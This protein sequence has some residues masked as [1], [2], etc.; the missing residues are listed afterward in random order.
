MIVIILVNWNGH[1]DTVECLEALMRLETPASA[2]RIIISD[3]LSKSG[4][5]EHII[6]WCRG[7]VAAECSS[8]AWKSL[9]QIRRYQPDFQ[10]L[11]LS[12]AETFVGAPM[13]TILRNGANLGFAGGNNTAVRL[14]LTDPDV[15]RV[16]LLNNDTICRPDALD[17]L[18][19]RMVAEPELGIVGSTLAYYDDPTKV[20]G[21]AG[22]FNGHAGW[23]D[24]IGKFVS[25]QSLP[26]R[27]EVERQMTYVIGA[28]MFVSRNFLVEVGLMSEDYFLYFEE[29]D[30][31]ERNA[32][33]F[34][35]GWEP[36][37]IVFHKEGGS[38]GTSQRQRSSDTSIY[39]A[40]RNLLT[41]TWKYHR[42]AMPKIAVRILARVARYLVR[43][44]A[45]GAL[46][47]LGA[48]RDFLLGRIGWQPI[49]FSSRVKP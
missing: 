20:Q 35:L 43:R 31:S 37:S 10:V 27:A 42:N 46:V 38:I 13:I 30:W 28:S 49:P 25:L 11:D 2:F 14:A 23:G 36:E 19:A 12:A 8:Q 17:H 48:C 7:E 21:L 47:A 32:G 44:D 29:T 39:Y 41:Y 18:A 40:N 22:W 6:A 1:K 33:R 3:N 16:W 24:H 45:R 26:D 15:D 5:V 34:R 4:S 9:P